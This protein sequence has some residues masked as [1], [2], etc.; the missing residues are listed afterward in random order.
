MQ[1]ARRLI[2]LVQPRILFVAY[3]IRRRDDEKEAIRIIS[4]RQASRREREAYSQPQFDCSDIP[5]P[6]D[7]QLNL[8]PAA[9]VSVHVLDDRLEA[10][11]TCLGCLQ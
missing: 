4:A 6:T 7:E 5:E 2:L 3:T 10:V 11:R 8:N 9:L 1:G